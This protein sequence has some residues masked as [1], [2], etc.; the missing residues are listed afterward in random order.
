[1]RF[2]PQPFSRLIIRVGQNRI[3]LPYVTVY[4]VIALPK[5]PYT[6][7]INM[8]LANPTYDW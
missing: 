5:I 4:V 7:R 1:M 3:Y 6:H 2:W 8:V